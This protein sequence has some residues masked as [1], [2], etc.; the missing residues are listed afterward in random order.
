V[1]CSLDLVPSTTCF[2]RLTLSSRTRVIEFFVNRAFHDE[3]NQVAY[4]YC[5]KRDGAGSSVLEI[6][7]SLVRQLAYSAKHRKVDDQI[8]SLWKGRSSPDTDLLTLRECKQILP[9]LLGASSCTTSLLIDA[10]D[11]CEKPQQLLS[12]LREI[13]GFLQK[14]TAG[15]GTV[16]V[17]LSSR[18]DVDVSRTF[19]SCDSVNITPA[20]V[21]DD[22]AYFVSRFVEIQCARGHELGDEDNAAMRERLIQ[23]V[24]SRGQGR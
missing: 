14:I 24:T 5:N 17:F 15:S 3:Q 2:R 8:M 6:L 18:D 16:R 7:R 19:P 21:T 10:L 23:S 12:E 22:F 4:F 11:E 1:T 13:G 9:R 20:S